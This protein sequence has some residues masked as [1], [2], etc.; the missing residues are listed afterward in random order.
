VSHACCCLIE[1]LCIPSRSCGTVDSSS[2]PFRCSGLCQQVSG[3]LELGVATAIVLEE[4]RMVGGLGG[5]TTSEMNSNQLVSEARTKK[6]RK[7][8]TLLRS[9]ARLDSGFGLLSAW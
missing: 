7:E 2:S 6:K 1:S 9:P 5:S 4:A 8:L 3:Y